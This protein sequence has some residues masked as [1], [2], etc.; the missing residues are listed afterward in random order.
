MKRSELPLAGLRV[1]DLTLFW[2]GP[3]PSAIFADLGA[4]VIKVESIQHLD[5]FRAYAVPG[6]ASRER[7]HERSPLFNALNRNKLGL[8]LDLSS[9][10]GRALF[11]KLVTKSDV[12]I[13]N[14]SPRVLPQ[15]DLGY[16]R[17]RELNPKIVLTSISGFGQDGPWRDY[18]SF[19]AIGEAVSGVSSLTGYTGEGALIHGVGV[20][21]PYAGLSAAFA[22]L[23]AVHAAR[24]SG[25]GTHIDVAQ[26]E[27][28]I[29]F[30]ADAFLDWAMNGR[31]RERHTNEDPWRAPHGV[32]PTRGDDQWMTISVGTEAQWRALLAQMD[33]PSWGSDE[34]FATALGRFRNREELAAQVTRWTRAVD[35]DATA[36]ALQKRGVPAA[37]V[38][39][40]AEQTDDAERRASGFFQ[41]VDHPVAGRLPYASF[42]ARIDGAYPPIERVGPM[43][44]ADNHFV[45][46]EILGVGE[47]E[48]ARLEDAQVIGSEPA[49]RA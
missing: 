19:A 32:F 22:T 27:A 48:I 49:R 26:L 30:L 14:Y 35:K 13:Q 16:A 20:S 39:K 2:A 42:P 9:E 25:Q 15:F 4:E 47:A 37:P 33:A 41:W 6:D 8:T 23:A 45:L 34:R 43:L 38:R 3:L 44:G 18:V 28:T 24:K 21:D 5:P 17:L 11:R 40:P 1:V 31:C 36:A 10:D 46:R 12:V 29:P 7:A